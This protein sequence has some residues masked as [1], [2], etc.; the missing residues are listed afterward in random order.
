[1]WSANELTSAPIPQAFGHSPPPPHSFLWQSFDP[2]ELCTTPSKHPEKIEGNLELSKMSDAYER[3]Q[4]VPLSP[5]CLPGCLY[6]RNYVSIGVLIFWNRQNNALLNSLSSKVSALRSVTIDIHDNA[7]DQDTL[8]HTVCL[9]QSVAGAI[10][11]QDISLSLG[12]TYNWRLDRVN[13]RL[14]ILPF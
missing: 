9:E 3:E 8:D 6:E 10:M 1:M 7:R 5:L 11:I 13:L 2:C 4:Y 12:D 14:T